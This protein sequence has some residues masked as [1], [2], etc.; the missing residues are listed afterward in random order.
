MMNVPTKKYYT[1]DI[2]E[3]FVFTFIG[4]Q[5]VSNNSAKVQ[6]GRLSKYMF[7]LQGATGNFP[8]K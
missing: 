1:E 3:G 7:L 6:S 8:L 4:I 2:F 5:I